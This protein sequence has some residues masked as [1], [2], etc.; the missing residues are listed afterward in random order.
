MKVDFSKT[1]EFK[2][3]KPEGTNNSGGGNNNT[4]SNEAKQRS[5]EEML[6]DL[7]DKIEEVT[8]TH[9]FILLV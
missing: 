1:V 7:F 6:Y 8:S 2:D 9:I 5:Q 3:I 4:T